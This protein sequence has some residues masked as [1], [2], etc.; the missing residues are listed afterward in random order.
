MRKWWFAIWLFGINVAC[1]NSYIIHK[2]LCDRAEQERLQK[3]A[4]IRC[5]VRRRQW[6][7]KHPRIQPMKHKKFI[8]ALAQDLATQSARSERRKRAAE[9]AMSKPSVELPECRKQKAKKGGHDYAATRLYKGKPLP[10][11][12]VNCTGKPSYPLEG[13]KLGRCQHCI[14]C[15]KGHPRATVYCS[16]CLIMCCDEQ[17]LQAYH[18]SK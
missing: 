8:E 13:Q 2:A 12:R 4:K 18:K 7:A 10:A 16:E 15:E 11:Q 17:C 6:E 14:W 3:R 9:P 5:P 1:T